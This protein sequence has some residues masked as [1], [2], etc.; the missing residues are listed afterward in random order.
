MP[1]VDH[2][3]LSKG[4]GQGPYQ[5]EVDPVAHASVALGKEDEVHDHPVN[6]RVHSHS[7]LSPS[8]Q[9]S[10]H[11]GKPTFMNHR[12]QHEQNAQMRVWGP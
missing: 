12:K 5:A 1:M 4:L 9:L 2:D 6:M 8:H 11:P 3:G 10:H 7:A